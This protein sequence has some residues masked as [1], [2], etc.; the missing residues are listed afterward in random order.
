M[1]G[2]G[3]G[4]NNDSSTS[5]A[6][7]SSS[8]SNS[9]NRSG[10]EGKQSFDRAM[11]NAD[12]P[13]RKQASFS[14]SNNA[15]TTDKTEARTTNKRD[16]TPD[17]IAASPDISSS[18]KSD[19]DAAIEMA[20]IGATREE[21]LDLVTAHHVDGE[22]LNWA[23]DSN[24]ADL[25]AAGILG[26]GHTIRSDFDPVPEAVGTRFAYPALGPDGQPPNYRGGPRSVIAEK[27]ELHFMDSMLNTLRQENQ[28]VTME[29]LPQ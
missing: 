9:N 20:N 17:P 10:G 21:A 2:S 14:A 23:Q 5:N 6:N 22:V 8:G 18:P 27:V 26:A 11:D 19:R 3:V 15:A 24:A 1:S 12:R 16:N 4:A 7:H 13:D 25:A 29:A 28:R